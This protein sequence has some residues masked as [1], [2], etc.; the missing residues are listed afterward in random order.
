MQDPSFL[1]PA[2]AK[3]A[4]IILFFSILA[5]HLP[6]ALPL[7]SLCYCLNAALMLNHACVSP[8]CPS[9]MSHLPVQKLSQIHSRTCILPVQQ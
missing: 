2:P 6:A 5:L 8:A 3:A 7:H 4:S 1:G 9:C